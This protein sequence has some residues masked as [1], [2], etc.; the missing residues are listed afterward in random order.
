MKKQTGAD[1]PEAVELSFQPLTFWP[2]SVCEELLQV[3]QMCFLLLTWHLIVLQCQPK[4]WQC[5]VGQR[6]GRSGQPMS[7][8]PAD[9]HQG[10]QVPLLD[11]AVFA[12]PSC[13]WKQLV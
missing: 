7:H 1:L 6:Q 13:C 5:P 8:L 12:V 4:H 2:N 11:L 9:E 10:H 3:V